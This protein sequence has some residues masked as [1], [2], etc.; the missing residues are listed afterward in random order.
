MET[1]QNKM[2]IK[3]RTDALKGEPTK[4]SVK[5]RRMRDTVKKKKTRKKRKERS[6]PSSEVG[7]VKRYLFSVGAG[8]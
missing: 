2:K 7:P 5:E 6:A 4:P 1:K 8:S 3:T